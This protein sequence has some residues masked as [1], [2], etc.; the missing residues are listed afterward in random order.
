MSS[1]IGGSSA[2]GLV[3]TALVVMGS[4]GPSTVSLVAVS[5]AYGVRQAIAYGVG[6]VVGTIGVLLAVA[7][8]VTVLLLALPVLRWVL[9]ALAVAYALRLAVRLALSS[10]FG[11]EGTVASRL[12]VGGGVLLGALNPKAWVAISAVFLSA[13]LVA[14]PLLD[15]TVKV[16]VLAAVIVVVHAAWLAAGRSL[17]PVLRAPRRARAA[18]LVLGCLLALAMIPVV[19]P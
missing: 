6:L 19:L 10:T 3:V 15:A 9:L 11:G 14:A 5:A 2:L 12:S 7:G 13:H 1:A 4:P 17:E 8:G 18:N 16:V